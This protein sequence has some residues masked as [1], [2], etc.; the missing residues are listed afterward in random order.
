MN[1][2]KL[3][4]YIRDIQYSHTIKDVDYDK[5]NLIVPNIH[6]NEDDIITLCFKHFSNHYENGDLI[7]IVGNIRSYSQKLSEDKNKVNIYVFT[8][9]DTPQGVEDEPITNQVELDGRICKIDNIRKHNTGPDSLSFILANNIILPEGRGKIN[10]YIPVVCWGKHATEL[11]ALNVSDRIAIRG[12][13]QSR[14]YK[15][16]LSDDSVELRV[17]HEIVLSGYEFL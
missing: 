13:L 17:A 2:I 3:R 14:T 16:H 8:Y 11:S 9:F 4:G 1:E 10:N 6:T 5:A 15:K 12:S 7:D